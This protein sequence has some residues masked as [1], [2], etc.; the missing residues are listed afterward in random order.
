MTIT[1][2]DP[3]IVVGDIGG[4]DGAPSAPTQASVIVG[5]QQTA[6]PLASAVIATPINNTTAT[7][8]TTS[9]LL[10]N[11]ATIQLASGNGTIERSTNPDGS[12]AVKV[13]TTTRQQQTGYN[14]I[15]TEYFHIPSNMANTVLMTLAAGVPPSSLYRTNMNTRTETIS[16]PINATAIAPPTPAATTTTTTQSSPNNYPTATT[17][18]PNPHANWNNSVEEERKQA[19]QCCTVFAVIVIIIVA[20]VFAVTQ[21]NDDHSSPT[22]SWSDDYYPSPYTPSYPSFPSPLYPTRN[23][24]CKPHVSPSLAPIIGKYKICFVYM[25]SRVNINLTI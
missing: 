3:E 13:I 23:E 14:E 24:P 11:Q 17:V 6:L 15:T 25:F 12:L 4:D 7:T 16:T 9:E 19:A 21:N 1:N 5:E 18:R 20:V 10:P 8:A 22:P 2:D